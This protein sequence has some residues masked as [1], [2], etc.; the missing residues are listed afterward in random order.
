MFDTL[1]FFTLELLFKLRVPAGNEG[2]F[3]RPF[4]GHAEKYAVDNSGR[5]KA[6]LKGCLLGASLRAG[7]SARV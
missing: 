1:A 2:W 6:E 3:G 5:G 7:E 4:Y